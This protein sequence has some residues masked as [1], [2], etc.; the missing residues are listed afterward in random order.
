MSLSMRLSL[1]LFV[2]LLL[3]PDFVM[4]AEDSDSSSSSHVSDEEPLPI[5][6]PPPEK[7]DIVLD[8][9][10]ESE[11]ETSQEDSETIQVIG[12][13]PLSA[14]SDQTIRNKDFMTF[15]R[16]SASDLLRFVPGLHITQHTGGAKAHQIFLRGFDAEHGQDVAAY[17]DG[18]PLNETSHVHGIGYL[19]LHFII[20]KEYRKS[21][22]LPDL[23]TP[24]SAISRRRA[25]STSNPTSNEATTTALRLEEDRTIS[26]KASA[27][28]TKTG[29]RWIPT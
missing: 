2:L 5:E 14:A 25:S 23:M 1:F 4:S 20:R 19:D 15:P 6:A 17:L 21:G 18:I 7:D 3:S 12:E 16:R 11:E 29:I 24:G 28:Y 22:L 9:S 8:M 10:M 27:R 13:R 26:R